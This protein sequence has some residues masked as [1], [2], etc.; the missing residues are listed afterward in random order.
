MN[1]IRKRNH[2][3]WLRLGPGGYL[4]LAVTLFATRAGFGDEPAVEQPASDNLA[5]ATVALTI[6]FGNGFRKSYPTIPA[7]KPMTVADAMRFASAHKHPTQF[8]TRG[9]KQTA[10][11]ES[12]DGI[13]HEGY[14][15]R[16]WIFY[17]NGKKADQSYGTASLTAGDTVLW[18]FQTFP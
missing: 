14:G 13:Q 16:C 3:H 6:D 1:H 5:P 18:R 17:V 9:K 11:L 7:T 12:I 4:L 8:T 2:H 10:F 15:K